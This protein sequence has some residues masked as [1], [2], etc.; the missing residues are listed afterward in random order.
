MTIHEETLTLSGFLSL[1]ASSTAVLYRGVSN[2][3]EPTQTPGDVLPHVTTTLEPEQVVAGILPHVITTL[4]PVQEISTNI[5]SGDIITTITHSQT[6][7]TNIK[8]PSVTTTLEPTQTI[9][10]DDS[11]ISDSELFEPTVT[12]GFLITD[13]GTFGLSVTSTLVPEQGATGY[14]T[15]I[16][17]PP[18]ARVD[19]IYVGDYS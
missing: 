18:G 9:T 4:E 5:K 13:G 8:T 7:E 14:V 2:T 16:V 17:T 3:L 1:A 15:P 19:S 6:I 12:L 10:I 11:E